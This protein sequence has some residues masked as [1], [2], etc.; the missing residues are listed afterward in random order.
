MKKKIIDK[1][2]R[3]V[4]WFHQSGVA[5]DQLRNSQKA[6]NV[7]EGKIKHLVGDV[8]SRWNSQLHMLERFIAM[9]GTV[10]GIL[11]N[12]PNAPP[13]IQASEIAVLKGS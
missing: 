3:I 12:Y 1:V 8:S 4:Q 10:G 9:S 7:P 2:R 5:A 6:E 13:M 11:L